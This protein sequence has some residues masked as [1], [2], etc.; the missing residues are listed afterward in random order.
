MNSEVDLHCK[1]TLNKVEFTILTD[2]D[3]N[4]NGNYK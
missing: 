2:N 1:Y 3:T 4:N